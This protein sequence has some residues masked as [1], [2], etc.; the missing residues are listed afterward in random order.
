MHHPSFF[1]FELWNR[2]GMTYVAL[3]EDI[4]N[5]FDHRRR[6]L[7]ADLKKLAISMS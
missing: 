6:F 3:L 5:L 2:E 4:A 7:L 1:Y